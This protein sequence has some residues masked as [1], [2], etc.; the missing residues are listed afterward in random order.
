[1][2]IPT[3]ILLIYMHGRTLDVITEY[4]IALRALVILSMYLYS[5]TYII[6]TPN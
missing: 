2:N 3:Y 4:A 5:I 6:F 1:M